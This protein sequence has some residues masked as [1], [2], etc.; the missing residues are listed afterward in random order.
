MIGRLAGTLVEKASNRIILDVRGVGYEV[1]VPLSTFYELGE[2]GSQVVLRIHTH[3][4][5]DILSLYGF[6]TERE[7]SL[8]TLLIQISGIGPKLANTVLSG[9]P[10]EELI[11][12][13]ARGD[14][15]RLTRIPGVGRKTAERMILELKEKMTKLAPAGE[16]E[17]PATTLGALQNDVISAL[18]NLGYPR[19]QSEKAVSKAAEAGGG[20][21]FETLLK[22]ALRRFS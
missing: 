12:A 15:V 6:F 2:E 19:N 21:Q 9:L 20:D 4:K 11:S 13:V 3:V 18:V 17:G 16:G 7:K 14:L 22:A 5:E 10:S 8:F 1:Q